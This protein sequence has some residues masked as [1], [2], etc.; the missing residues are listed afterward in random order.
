M[1]W[2]SNLSFVLLWLAGASWMTLL[3][4]CGDKAA[5]QVEAHSQLSTKSEITA[6][7]A[8]IPSVA[9]T[10]GAASDSSAPGDSLHRPFAQACTTEV[11]A[12]SGVALPPVYTLTGKNTG[13]LNEAIQEIWDQI[14]FVDDHGKPQTYVLEFEVAMGNQALGTL[15]ILTQPEWAPN[16]VRNFVAL[17]RVGY[18]DGLRFD[19]VVR[20]R[21]DGEAGG[22]LLLVEAGSPVENA[23]PAVSHLGYW[24]LPEFQSNIKHE[25]GI[26]GACLMPSEDNAETA[27]CRFYIALTPAPAMDGNFTLFG[28]VTKG[29]DL[30]RRISEQPVLSQEAGP[31]QGRFVQPVVIRKAIARPLP[32]IK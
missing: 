10:K 14:R 3:G 30:V 29:L 21:V 31:D 7:A 20:Q 25:A 18:Y 9:V 4:G 15:E 27:A 19:R 28:R 11:N 12:D 22:E 26:V 8:S 5:P 1:K 6:P 13:S 24:L 17:T 2:M 16:H 23:D 32:V